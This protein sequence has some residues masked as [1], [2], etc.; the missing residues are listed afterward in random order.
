M[1]RI[2]RFLMWPLVFV[3]G[4]ALGA[5]LFSKT[6]RRPLIATQDCHISNACLNQKQLLALFASVGL[7]KFPGSIP[8]IVM[9]T[10]KTIVVT[11]PVSDAKVD[12][13]V[14]PKKDITD[15]GNL[16]SEDTPYLIDAYA[17]IDQLIARDKAVNYKVLT[18]GPGFQ[19][20]AYLHFHLEEY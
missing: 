13:V 7:E 12:Y 17:V 2:V 16:G 5:F 20:V 15:I 18:N 11:D 14:I 9:E 19:D 3:L 8:G 10:D 1:K 4:F 6:V